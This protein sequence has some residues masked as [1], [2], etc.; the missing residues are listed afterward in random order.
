MYI[1]PNDDNNDDNLTKTSRGFIQN[2][3]EAPGNIMMNHRAPEI[4]KGGG[5][6]EKKEINRKMEDEHDPTLKLK[7]GKAVRSIAH[8][9]HTAAAAREQHI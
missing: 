9:S 7:W 3:A 8:I 6:R 5:E 1:Q 4:N 2:R